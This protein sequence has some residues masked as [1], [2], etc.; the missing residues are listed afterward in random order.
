MNRVCL[1]W[2]IK[3]I[4]RSEWADREADGRLRDTALAIG[5]CNA[6]HGDF[7]PP[8]TPTLLDLI[9]LGVRLVDELHIDRA[10]VRLH[11]N[12]VLGKNGI[13]GTPRSRI[14]Y[15]RLA[16]RCSDVPHQAA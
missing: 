16:Q 9:G 1:P 5:G 12:D 3:A 4:F 6:S 8:F 10:D 11:R 2:Q 15:A 7:P 13:Q 14:E